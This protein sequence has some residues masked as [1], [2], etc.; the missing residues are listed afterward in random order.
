V[1]D[2]LDDR[3]TLLAGGRTRR[4][5]RQQTLQAVMQWSWDLLT[6]EEQQ[7]LAE[8]SVFSGG[9]TLAAAER[10]TSAADH[11]M[12]ALMRSLATKSLIE[13]VGGRA[14]MRYRML[15]TVRLFS[16]ERLAESGHAAETRDRHA[17]WLV[18]RG[19]QRSTATKLMEFDWLMSFREELD[20]YVTAITWCLERHRWDDAAAL[21]GDGSGLWMFDVLST[22]VVGWVED[23]L[24]H[25]LDASIRARVLV[26]GFYAAIVSGHHAHADIWTGQAVAAVH[27]DVAARSIACSWRAAPLMIYDPDAAAALLDE[28][29][30]NARQEG[31]ASLIG[32]V[33]GWR[34]TAQICRSDGDPELITPDDMDRLGGRDTWSWQGIVQTGSVAAALVGELDL[35]LD[36]CDAFSPLPVIPIHWRDG[37]RMICTALAGDTSEA[38]AMAKAFAPVATRQSNTMWHAETVLTLGVIDVREGRPERAAGLIETARHAPMFMPYFY[39]IARIY[40]RQAQADLTAGAVH[41]HQPERTSVQQI[42]GELTS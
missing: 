8:L 21:L 26:A 39:A 28:A 1:L 22:Q 14:W 23:V 10:V 16:Q 2:R 17:G 33:T 12:T 9:W 20:N 7:L 18:N 37:F 32:T 11:S 34:L 6:G 13:P 5:Q 27:H 38:R 31:S 42:L 30:R 24:A 29:E 25:D 3:F 4:R 35:A 41:P 40:L 19:A 15:E 36:L